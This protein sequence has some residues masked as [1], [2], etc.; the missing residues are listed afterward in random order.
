MS[1]FD[2]SQTET[3]TPSSPSGSLFNFSAPTKTATK[4]TQSPFVGPYASS[5]YSPAVNQAVDKVAPTITSKVSDFF[6]TI[7]SNAAKGNEKVES[8]FSST[9]ANSDVSSLLGKASNFIA[10]AAEEPVYTNNSWSQT[11]RN[12]PNEIVRTILPNAAALNDDPE[13][14]ALIKNTDIAKEVPNLLFENFVAPL[15]SF[16]QTFYGISNKILDK[17]GFNT[18]GGT[19]EDPGNV[20]WSIPG[21]G[22]VT[23][24][25]ARLADDIAHNGIPSSNLATAG[26]VAEYTGV[27]LLNGLFAASLI[28]GV[29]N[30]RLTNIADISAEQS[31]QLNKN[32]N[33]LKVENPIDTSPKSF[34]LYQKPT[35][36]TPTFTKLSDEFMQKLTKSGIDMSKYNSDI[37]TFFKFEMEPGGKIT[38]KVVQVKPSFLDQFTNLFKSDITKVPPGQLQILNSKE[39]NINDIEKNKTSAGPSVPSIKDINATAEEIKNPPLSQSSQY[40]DDIERTALGFQPVAPEIEG[41]DLRQGA[42]LSADEAHP[43]SV[44]AADH[45][46]NRNIQP[47][48]EKGK[49]AIIGSDNLKDYFGRDYNSNNHPVYSQA[50]DLLYKKAVASTKNPVVKFTVGGT[51]SGKS[52]FLVPDMANNFSGV[53]YDSTGF[54]YEGIKKQI[55][56]AKSLGKKPEVYAIVPDIAR[57]RAYTLQREANGEHPVSEAAFIKTHSQAIETL[58]KLIKD[59]VDVNII[60]TRDIYIKEDIKNAGYVK[61]P[62]DLLQSLEYD[63]D[64]VKRS[65]AGITKENAQALIEGGKEGFG[66]VS[67]ENRANEVKGKFSEKESIFTKGREKLSEVPVNL[68]RVEEYKKR[69]KLRGTDP[70]LVNTIIT[71][72][73]TRAFGVSFGGHMAFE[74]IVQQF[75]EDHEVFHQVFQNM[76]KMRLF[77]NFDK[78]ALL[79]EA[80]YIY[81]DQPVENL[82]EELAKDFQEYVREREAGKESSFFDRILDFFKRLYASLKRLF[83]TKNDIEEFFRVMSEGKATEETILDVDQRLKKFSEKAT[84]KGEVDFRKEQYALNKFLEETP[85]EEVFNDDGNLTLKTLTKLKGRA[86]VSKQFIED[87]SNSGDIKQVERDLIRSILETEPDQVNVSEFAEKVKSELLPLKVDKKITDGRGGLSA[88]YESIALPNELRGNVANYHENIYESPIKTSAGEVHF[89]SRKNE[90]YFG[91]TRIEDMAPSGFKFGEAK[92]GEEIAKS[93]DN[94]SNGGDTRRVIEVQSDLYQKGNLERETKMRVARANEDIGYN[95]EKEGEETVKARFKV[96]EDKAQK[97]VNK[98]QQYNDPTAHF[99]MVR[100][101]V[102]KAAQDGKTKLQFPTGATAMKIEGLSGG[103]S[104]WIQ[105]NGANLFEDGLRVGKNIKNSADNTEWVVTDIQGDGKFG[106]IKKIEVEKYGS[107]E[108]ALRNAGDRAENF[109]L[110][111][112]VDTSSPIYKFYEKDLGK[113]LKNNYGAKPV[114]DDKGVTWM[115]VPVDPTYADLPVPA[116]NEKPGD[117]ENLRKQLDRNEQSLEVARSNPDMFAKAYGSSRM[118]ELKTKN[119]ELRRRITEAKYPRSESGDK[120]ADARKA[121]SFAENRVNIKN[122][123]ESKLE[124]IN[125]VIDTIETVLEEHPGKKLQKFVSKKEGVFED[126]QNPELAKTPSE[127]KSIQERNKKVMKSAM[128]ALEGTKFSDEFDNPDTIREQIDEYKGLQEHIQELKAK[129]T[130]VRKQVN[131]IKEM[132]KSEGKDAKTLQNIL[133]SQA[134]LSESDING[135]VNSKYR[136]TRKES[137]LQKSIREDQQLRRDYLDNILQLTYELEAP[138][139]KERLGTTAQA[140]EGAPITLEESDELY[141]STLPKILID[142]N[143]PVKYKV[144]ILDYLRTPDRVLKKIGLQSLIKPLRFAYEGYLAE[145]PTHMDLIKYWAD[146][147]PE[148]GSSERIFRYLDGQ[149][150]RDYFSN[151]KIK[152]QLSPKE[153]EVAQEIKTYLK[154]WAERLGLPEDKQLSHYITH[155]FEIGTNEKEFD[156]EVAKIIEKKIPGSVYDPFLLERLGKKGYIEDVFRALEAYSKRAVRKANMDPVLEKIKEN[157]ERL[158]LSQQNYV[159]KLVDKINFRPTE[160]ENLVDNTIKQIVGYRL[161]QRPVAYLT[162]V[163]RKLVFRAALGL[164]IKSAVKNLTQGVNTYAKLGEKYTLIGYTKLLT[165]GTKELQEV[166]ILGQDMVQDRTVSA[167]RKFMQKFDDTLFYLFELAEKIN[168]GSAYYGAKAKAIDE[169]KSEL[170]AI[171]AGKKLVRDT[172]FQF[173]SIDMPVG[174]NSAIMKTLTQFLSFGVKQAEFLTEMGKNKEWASI[175]RYIAASLIMI[176]VLGKILGLKWKDFV[177]FYSILSRFGEVP[178]ALALPW[179]ITKAALDVPDQYGKPVPLIKKGKDIIK[180][181]PYPAKTQIEKTIKGASAFISNTDKD[182]SPITA[183]KNL[184]FGATATGPD[185]LTSLNSEESKQDKETK[186]AAETEWAR[187]KNIG[188]QNKEA[189]LE[190]LKKLKEKD[191]VF[192]KKVYDIIQ[193]DKLGLTDADKKIKALGVENGNRAQYIYDQTLKLETPAEKKAYVGDLMKKKI[194]SDQVLKQIAELARKDKKSTE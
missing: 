66:K 164:N 18:V 51:G 99:R 103:D 112:E 185:E 158:E 100:E 63:E 107:V 47:M 119:T 130:K 180:N 20:S 6:K 183:A 140:L 46:W 50:A 16:A 139:E 97:E 192:Y 28:S 102:K 170:E 80:Q 10:G 70:I 22:K 30:P 98:L 91:H 65:I 93:Q 26:T 132:Q 79:E 175:I 160:T 114:T 14:A 82:E 104:R 117:I 133:N 19:K 45:Y 108:E 120:L 165:L 24:L 21:L 166:G 9:K 73:G 105:D 161:G 54:N 88:Q 174:L 95:L 148:E 188:K 29:V 138:I 86:T 143:T 145:L 78:K 39:V 15:A 109:S 55:D 60:D 169:G 77:K 181:I 76:D 151:K 94:F 113:Y 36:V 1:L 72:T 59:G 144:G 43:L 163:A 116:F 131:Q 83:K 190:E 125:D 171:E 152:D 40:K 142:T 74:N 90:G 191:P 153:L 110:K 81:G 32:P 7:S 31:A 13:S 87:L 61:N 177:P 8:D 17:A 85:L 69:L 159:K 62:L 12:L 92:T 41:L 48:I 23:N 96:A 56:Y 53:V 172:Q 101:E 189:G 27:E 168:R 38:G 122:D 149:T 150:N 2:F 57:S 186:A 124:G 106:A 42:R 184:I 137:V 136:A 129:R 162:G 141:N 121:L 84:T 179:A 127:A 37:P 146:R 178:P 118:D 147:V 3:K 167:T 4:S 173:G 67:E 64:N 155:I 115:E 58:I 182:K 25:Q 134:K 34:Q 49:A 75:T 5:Y 68:E 52:D 156:E 194:V 176:V 126:F 157:A 128:S 33:I 89:Q 35:M 193:E 123:I 135:I 44:K 187:I 11:F 71:P 111:I 154:D